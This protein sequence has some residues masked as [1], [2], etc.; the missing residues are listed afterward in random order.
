MAEAFIVPQYEVEV[1]EL[2]QRLSATRLP[3]PP[4]GR[5]WESGVDYGYLIELIAHWRGR[6]DWRARREWLNTFPQ[7]M[8]SIDGQ[9]VH[10][11]HVRADPQ[12]Y[13]NAIPIVLSHGWPYSFLEFLPIVPW[14][15][16]PLGR[17]GGEAD[18]FDVV[19]P[20]L[21]GYGFSPKLAG[22]PF[23]SEV[24]AQLWHRLMTEELGYERYA[25]YGED[26]GTWISDWTAALYPGSIIGLFSTH[27]AFPP[28]ERGDD[29]SEAEQEF[30]QW[31]AD[32][33]RDAGAYSEIQA[34][35]PDTLA[36]GLNDSPAG[37]L[38]WLLEKFHE[39]SGPDFAE[40]W[41][42][43]DILTTVSLYWLTQTIGTSFLPYFDG[44]QH[45]QPLP[46][47]DVPVGVAVQWG[48][49]GFP[50]EYAERTYTDLRMWS[51]LPRGGH[52]TAKQT[53]D[54]VAA[55]MRD[56]FEPLRHRAR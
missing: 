54:L 2:R 16:D 29:L 14:L 7:F 42:R 41:S 27:A 45:D 24:V 33:W 53:P 31:L 3:P 19:I 23:T 40:S 48:E 1:E 44:R 11:V 37:L 4:V 38:A 46:K 5:S 34:T 25:T 36:V 43:D 32:K 55:A 50:R 56:F 8:V 13:P 47:V 12:V 26:V 30:K 15:T 22:Q 18:A 17:A 28:D 52:F 6:F 21:P 9:A 51:D 39:W 35:R 10:F 49:R 20:S